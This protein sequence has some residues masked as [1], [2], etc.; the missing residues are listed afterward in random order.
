MNSEKEM[1]EK[2]K[3]K[4]SDTVFFQSIFVCIIN[5][6]LCLICLSMASWAWFY[7]SHTGAG[8]TLNVTDYDLAVNIYLSD[9]TELLPD[10]NGVYDLLAGNEYWL[11]FRPEGSS[12]NGYA[13]IYIDAGG[14]ESANPT[15]TDLIPITDPIVPCVIKVNP[16]IDSKMKIELRWG[17]TENQCQVNQGDII[18]INDDSTVSYISG[19]NMFE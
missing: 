17:T 15:Y 3:S 12:G 14:I 2:S 18:I 6:V 11:V 19:T 7:D 16:Q 9:N 8:M 13:I 1:S 4:L 10:D 5:I